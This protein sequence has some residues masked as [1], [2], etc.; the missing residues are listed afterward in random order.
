MKN[1]LGAKM[2]GYLKHRV[3]FPLKPLQ[4]DYISLRL[5]TFLARNPIL[6]S[7]SCRTTEKK[8]PIGNV[9]K[10]ETCDDLRIVRYDGQT[11][12]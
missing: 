12:M 2:Q 5:G 1:P 3:Q 4:I 11:E 9:T 6:Y 10:F 7:L 8:K